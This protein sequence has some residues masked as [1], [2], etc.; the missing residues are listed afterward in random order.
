MTKV[1]VNSNDRTSHFLRKFLVSTHASI[2]PLLTERQSSLHHREDDNCAPNLPELKR[3]TDT[4][5]G[6]Q[7]G[8]R[9]EELHQTLRRERLATTRSTKQT[10]GVNTIRL[11]SC[12]SFTSTQERGLRKH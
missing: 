5:H 6:T 10:S 12:F 8:L 9:G 3:S 4:P 11:D 1:G 2:R 7:T